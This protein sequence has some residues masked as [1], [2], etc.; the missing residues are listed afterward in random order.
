MRG[1]CRAP[2]PRRVDGGVS[3]GSEEVMHL[4]RE[5]LP[6]RLVGRWEKEDEETVTTSKRASVCHICAATVCI[7]G[8]QVTRARKL[9]FV[10]QL[11]Y[12]NV[13]SP[14]GKTV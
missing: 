9:K 8:V 2:A 13:E 1:D 6:C 10:I 11:K 5:C 14:T 12:C 4:R 7:H 3:W